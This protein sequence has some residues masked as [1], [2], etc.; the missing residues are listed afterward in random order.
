MGL[1]LSLLGLG[2]AMTAIQGAAEAHDVHKYGHMTSYEEKN[3]DQENAR[4]GIHLGEIERIAQ[5]CRVKPSKYGILPPKGYH[6]C[7][8]YVR[9]YANSPDDVDTFI[10]LW[11]MTCQ[12]Q[13]D[14]LPNI[15]KKGKDAQS[16]P[17]YK[18]TL[19]SI[20]KEL[21]DELVTYE[22]THWKGLS[23][24][25]HIKRME[26]ISKETALKHVLYQPPILRWSSTVRDAYTEYWTVYKSKNSFDIINRKRGFNTVYS[27][28]A[29]FLGY[30]A[31]L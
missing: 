22:I 14:N 4:D 31:M 18:H 10:K 11:K 15:I 27:V 19:E 9:K 8:G 12:E 20:A 7:L 25:E 23:K 29:A 2:A 6:K 13:R 24:A 17:T 28:C 26:K 3:F 1:L 5:R 16:Y 30:D 21:T